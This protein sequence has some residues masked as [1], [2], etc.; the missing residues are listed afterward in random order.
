MKK[1]LRSLLPALLFLLLAGLQSAMGCSSALGTEHSTTETQVNAC[2]FHIDFNAAEPC[3]DSAACHRNSSPVR[4][5]G[6]P[7]FANRIKD[8]LPLI[9]ESRQQIPQQKTALVLTQPT[10]DLQILRQE[11]VTSVAPRHALAFLRTTVLLH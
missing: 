4:H 10:I 9:L 2:H 7:E 5:F 6:S 3:C 11:P 8:L 1:L